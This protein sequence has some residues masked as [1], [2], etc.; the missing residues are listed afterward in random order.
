MPAGVTQ[1]LSPSAGGIQVRPA[2]IANGASQ[3]GILDLDG[4]ERQITG[5]QMPAAWTA[6]SV[7][8]LVSH[9]GVTFVPLYWASGEYTIAAGAGAA[10]SLA[11]SVEPSALLGWRFVRIRSG[12]A[13]TAVNQGAERTLMVLTR[14]VSS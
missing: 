10:A 4:G 3:S 6:A 7:T 12:V 8:F 11:F 9:D 5:I 1:R 13:A 14:P 2:V